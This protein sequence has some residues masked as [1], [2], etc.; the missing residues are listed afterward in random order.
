MRPS[1]NSILKVTDLRR[2]A[3]ALV[4]SLAIVAAFLVGSG[5]AQDTGPTP[6][7]TSPQAETS[8]SDSTARSATAVDVVEKSGIPTHPVEIIQQMSGWL[9]SDRLD[10][11]GLVHD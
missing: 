10:H 3:T 8:S 1:N 2:A 11:F 4:A 6:I 7:P 9:V 5:Q